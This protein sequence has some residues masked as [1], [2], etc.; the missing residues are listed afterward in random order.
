MT[1]KETLPAPLNHPNHRDTTWLRRRWGSMMVLSQADL[2]LLHA[3]RPNC[4]ICGKPVEIIE[5]QRGGGG[6]RVMIYRVHCHGATE[7][8][9]IDFADMP[10]LMLGGVAGGV[11]FGDKPAIEHTP[12]LENET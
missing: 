9:R 2:D 3:L 8:T 7:E 12:K 5:W 6:E 11:A 1:K 10:A 4:A